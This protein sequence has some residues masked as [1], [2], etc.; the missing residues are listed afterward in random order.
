MGIIKFIKDKN[1]EYRIGIFEEFI[2]MISACILCFIVG[3]NLSSKKNVKADNKLDDNLE[4]FID[5]YNYIINNYYKDIDK[6]QLIDDAIAGMMKTL[7]DP[8]SVYLNDADNRALNITLNGEYKGIGI[9][10]GKNDDKDIVVLNVLKDSPAFVAGVT[11]GDILKSID[12]KDTSEMETKDFSD[13]VAKKEDSEFKLVIIRDGEEKEIVV[14]KNN[15]ELDSIHS[16]I[17]NEKEHKIGYIYISVFAANTFEQFSSKLNEM[18]KGGIDSLII[19]VRDDS[20]GYLTTVDSILKSFM[21]KKQVIYQ[22]KKDKNISKVYGI[23]KKNKKYKIVLLGNENSASASELLISGIRENYD[24]SIFIGKKTYGKGTAQEMVSIDTNN[25]Y[26]I[27][28]KKWLTPKGNWIN[29]TEGIIPDVEI[30]TDEISIGDTN[31]NDLQLKMAIEE[32][33]K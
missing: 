14:T 19:D 28:T 33:T 6:K 8:Y 29:D 31:Y 13:Y 21:T 10:I 5:N 30:D 2:L 9:V 23:A 4:T 16:E 25:K 17:I 11:E 27:T 18:E 7:D 24:N 22:L 32:I 20:G 26:K 12:D 15:I 1:N 3:F